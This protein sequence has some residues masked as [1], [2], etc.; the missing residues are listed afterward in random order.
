VGL[1]DP[2]RTHRERPG[3]GSANEFSPLAGHAC[4]PCGHLGGRAALQ[5]GALLIAFPRPRILAT[6]GASR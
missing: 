2:S 5:I 4:H 1:A 3:R 6:D